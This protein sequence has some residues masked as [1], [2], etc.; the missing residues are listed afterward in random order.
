VR[1]TWIDD[2]DDASI[3]DGVTILTPPAETTVFVLHNR[4]IRIDNLPWLLFNQ[5][6]RSQIILQKTLSDSMRFMAGRHSDILAH[7][8]HYPE[9]ESL[10]TSHAQQ[11]L[12]SNSI[13]STTSGLD[14]MTLNIESMFDPLSDIGSS[15]V[16][17]NSNS[18]LIDPEVSA[19][20]AMLLHKETAAYRGTSLD[21]IYK[22]YMMEDDRAKCY[23]TLNLNTQSNPTVYQLF[24]LFIF[25]VTNN[26]LRTEF[27][28]DIY[29]WAKSN[30]CSWIFTE[31]LKSKSTTIDV[32]ATKLFPAA[33]QAGDVEMVHKL[34]SRNVDI[35]TPIENSWMEKPF[36]TALSLAVEE[37]N[38]EMIK[39]LCDLGATPGIKE[40]DSLAEDEGCIASLWSH[41][42]I[43]ILRLLLDHGADPECLVLGQPRGFPLIKAA[44]EGSVEAVSLL[45]AAGANV[46]CSISDRWGTALQASAAGGHVQVVRALLEAEA[47][48]NMVC[49]DV[50]GFVG[51][52]ANHVGLQTAIQLATRNNH[53]EI[54]LLLLQSGALVNFCPILAIVGLEWIDAKFSFYEYTRFSNGELPFAFAIQY[55]AQNKNVSLVHQLLAVGA[56][57]DS[58]IGIDYGD[59]PLQIAARLGNVELVSLLLTHNADVNAP[60]GKYNGR[61]AIQA[62]AESGNIKVIQLLLDAHA[63]IHASPGW[64]RGR[65]ALQAALEKGHVNAARRLL[66]AGADIN[67]KLGFM[68]GL[69]ALQAAV[70]FGDIEI[71]KEILSYRADVNAAAGSE[72][73]PTALQAAV[74]H[75]NIDLLGLLLQTGAEVDALPSKGHNQTALQSAVAMGWMEGVRLLL[76]YNPDVRMLP[77]H[78]DGKA[79]SAL[80]WAIEKRNHDMID[81][82]FDHGA[83][84]NDPISNNPTDPPTAFLYALYFTDSYECI[85]LFVKKGADI[86][87]RW[88]SKSALE[89]ALGALS[90]N[91][92]V[93]RMMI[94]LISQTTGNHCNDGIEKSLAWVDGET[95]EDLELIQLLLDAGADINAKNPDDE[96]TILQNSVIYGSF[97][98]VEFLL[99]NGAEVNIPATRNRGTPLQVAIKDKETKLADLLLEHGADVNAPPAEERGVTALQAAAI[100]GYI[101]LALKLLERGADVAAAPSPKYGRTTID[102]AAEHGHLDMLQLLLNAYGDR[103]GLAS[104]CDQAASFA[105]KEGYAAIGVWLRAYTAS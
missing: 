85:E 54:A 66:L 94:G 43:G 101:P 79:Y 95:T 67:A 2:D 25:M 100:H 6:L 49:T 40:Y 52:F 14:S 91:I 26:L 23:T 9:L 92:E 68:K 97:G 20:L 65:T 28:R 35:D 78:K 90:V 102:G 46:N 27:V 72:S 32:F 62:A 13:H 103:E 83:G 87:Q 63:N 74:R 29:G 76:D 37:R 15:W 21:S 45:L 56:M 86:D 82:L 58:R 8:I 98:A 55:A 39:V 12:V 99:R 50:N 1:L 44:S 31:I 69:T 36:R 48:V 24:S 22:T 89:V 41:E 81:L 73:G 16:N 4:V 93:V 7:S 70:S 96:R 5:E 17:T 3:P 77:P 88:G 11:G 60:P 64:S 71:V 47:N 33:V 57:V 61:T 18:M 53:T 84:P 51:H 80:G 105:E 10:E 34:V 59:T 30:S 42:S 104:V 38:M 19:S 75:K